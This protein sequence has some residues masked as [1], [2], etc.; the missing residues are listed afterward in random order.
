MQKSWSNQIKHSMTHTRLKVVKVA[1][2]VEPL[3]KS[4]EIDFQNFISQLKYFMEDTRAKALY[5]R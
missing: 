5:G 3:G 1:D 4:Q 2:Q